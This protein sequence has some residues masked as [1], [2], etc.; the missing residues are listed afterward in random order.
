MAEYVKKGLEKLKS[1]DFNT[2]NVSKGPDGVETIILSSEHYPEVYQ[3]RVKNLY[4][5]NEEVFD[6]DTGQFKPTRDL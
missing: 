2:M 1:G 3:F 5:E 4:Q 6:G